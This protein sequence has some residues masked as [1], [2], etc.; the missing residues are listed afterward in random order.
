MLVPLQLQLHKVGS[1]LM[2]VLENNPGPLKERSELLAREPSL[3]P[4]VIS[5]VAASSQ[6]W[7]LTPVP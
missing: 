6:A 5:K 7:E 1:C 3:Q 2:W 4:L